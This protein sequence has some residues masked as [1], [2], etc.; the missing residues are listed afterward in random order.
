MSTIEALAEL[1]SLLSKSADT[2]TEAD[3]MAAA[4][5]AQDQQLLQAGQPR[6]LAAASGLREHSARRQANRVLAQALRDIPPNS[7]PLNPQRLAVD[8]M[9]VIAELSPRYLNRFV[10]YIDT[11]LW[12]EQAGK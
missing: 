9:A 4:L 2:S 1:T 3:N 10:A 6:E 7:G 12:L 8:S 5:K 11:L